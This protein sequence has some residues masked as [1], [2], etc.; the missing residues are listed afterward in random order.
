LRGNVASF[1][2]GRAKATRAPIRLVATVAAAGVAVS[3]CS[4]MKMGAAA[5]TGNSRITSG[6]LTAQVANLNAAYKADQTKNIKP[7]RSKGQEAQQVLTWM[8][9][10]SIYNKLAAQ[11]H[12]TVTPA[13]SAKEL[14]GLASE[15]KSSGL[16]LSQYVSAAGAVPPDLLPQ[17]GQYLAI[18]TAL[19]NKLDGG[20]APTSTKTEDA[21]ES[22][23]DHE[24]CLAAK[25]LG[26]T[27]NPQYGRF[28]YATYSVVTAPPTL[29]ANPSPTPKASPVVSRP[30]C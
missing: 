13:D 16:N 30:P 8:I 20:K 15:A 9:T 18:L 22:K 3:A 2:R 7:Q 26:I 14:S 6:N 4:T 25:G 11:H 5:I 19:E 27:V 29:A 24:Q 23:I 1:I 10:F 12:I 28:D 17:L 21:L